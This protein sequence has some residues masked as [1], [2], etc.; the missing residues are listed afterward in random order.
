MYEGGRVEGHPFKLGTIKN[1]AGE[2]GSGEVGSGK[3][4]T[5]EVSAAQVGAAQV[6]SMRTDRSMKNLCSDG[7][8]LIVPRLVTDTLETPGCR[9]R[10]PR[11]IRSD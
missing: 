4:S 8:Q 6:N 5:R 2:V 9:S 3:V 11:P 10:Q 7:R 1:G